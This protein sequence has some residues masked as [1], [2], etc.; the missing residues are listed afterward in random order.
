MDIFLEKNTFN[1]SNDI[2][3]ILVL[4]TSFWICYFFVR[5]LRVE[6]LTVALWQITPSKL[7]RINIARLIAMLQILRGTEHPV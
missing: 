2:G 3:K 7:Q 4:V 5:N 6:K 1:L